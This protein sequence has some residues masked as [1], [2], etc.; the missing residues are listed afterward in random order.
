MMLRRLALLFALALLVPAC[1]GGGDESEPPPP[2]PATFVLQANGGIAT[3]SAVPGAS[4]GGQ[5][6]LFQISAGGSVTAGIAPLPSMPPLPVPPTSGTVVSS[7]AADVNQSSGN[8]L[9]PGTVTATGASIRTV[10]AAHGDI[11]VSGS[12]VSGQNAGAQVNLALNAPQGTVYVPGAIRTGSVDGVQDGTA[13]GTLSITASRIVVTG[14]IETTG[15]A[16]SSG[17]GAAGGSVTLT[18]SPSGTD[19]LLNGQFLLSGGNGTGGTG[20]AGG[21]LTAQAGTEVHLAGLVRSNGGTTSVATDTPTG[22]AGGVLSLQGPSGVF[23]NA[24]ADLIG[25]DTTTTGVGAQSG[26]PGIFNAS[27]SVG[28]VQLFGSLT[29]RAGHASA[30]S[31]T[32]LK[33]VHVGSLSVACTVSGNGGVDLGLLDIHAVGGSSSDVGG[34]GG[35]IQFASSAGDV[36]ISGTVDASGGSGGIQG[37]GAG[38]IGGTTQKGD[39]FGNATLTVRGGSG[40]SFP[41][42]GGTVSFLSAQATTT[43]GS[44]WLIGLVDTSG[45][46]STGANASGGSGG[47]VNLAAQG[48]GGRVTVDSGLT[49]LSNGGAA[50]GTGT[51]GGGGTINLMTVNGA[52]QIGGQIRAVGG[53]A[54]TSS[55]TG[56]Q[57][58]R[59]AVNSDSNSDGAGGDIT[60]FAGG[61]IDVSGGS[62]LNGGSARKGAAGSKAVEFDADGNNSNAGTNGLVVNFGIITATG[63]RSGGNGG[64]VLFDGLNSGLTPG[65]VPGL[66][67]ISGDGAGLNGIFTSQ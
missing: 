36:R 22:G 23:Y 13:S 37:G 29:I 1:G 47:I 18:T 7:L 15:E 9:L 60:L 38:F 67:S 24:T 10:T 55:G 34:G 35:T 30:A 16:N 5:C 6:P 42:D 62:G 39:V 58:G 27:A 45:G 43:S 31:S 54:S 52:I 44:V 61:I 64:D 65:P 32:A 51:G 56:G 8:V 66:Q 14:T 11:V 17:A 4:I 41:S 57:G 40:S 53:G 26:I 20:G 50:N 48:P 25:G 3:G 33:P 12:L 63:G 46:T 49:L 28:V 2:A 59:I 19:I 21:V